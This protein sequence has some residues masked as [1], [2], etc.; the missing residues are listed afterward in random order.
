MPRERQNAGN[1]ENRPS[2]NSVWTVHRGRIPIENTDARERIPTE[3]DVPNAKRSAVLKM[4]RGESK[5][6]DREDDTI[7][8]K[9]LPASGLE[10]TR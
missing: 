1:S 4:K 10:P 7:D 5:N 3:N 8:A 2:P 6:K 9:Q